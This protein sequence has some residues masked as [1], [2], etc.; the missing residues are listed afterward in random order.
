MRSSDVTKKKRKKFLRDLPSS[1]DVSSRLTYIVQHM[2]EQYSIA[3][4]ERACKSLLELTPKL[5]QDIVIDQW[6]VQSLY[7]LILNANSV[8]QVHHVLLA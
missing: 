7:N 1:D 2:Q 8:V 3:V 5:S 4:Q 6:A